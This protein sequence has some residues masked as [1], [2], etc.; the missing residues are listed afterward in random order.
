MNRT[1][2]LKIEGMSCQM[3][4]KHV[5][6]ALRDLKGVSEVAVNLESNTATVTYD[7]QLVG[8]E[9]FKAAVDEAGYAV[10]EN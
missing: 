10:L 5:T 3:C 9:D 1:D 2:T 6:K 8:Q 4:V 7:P